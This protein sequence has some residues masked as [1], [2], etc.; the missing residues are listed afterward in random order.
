[1][2]DMGIHL[3]FYGAIWDGISVRVE[4]LTRG[5]D[6]T[7]PWKEKWGRYEMASVLDAVMEGVKHIQEHYASII[8]QKICR[9]YPFLSSY[10]NDVEQK[11]V[12]F[13]YNEQLQ[14]DTLLFSATTDSDESIVVKFTT[15][16]SVDAHQHMAH[17]DMAPKIRQS[18]AIS[19]DWLAIVMDLSDYTSLYDLSPQLSELQWVKVQSR[20][21][22]IVQE[23]H[24]GCF[25]HGDIRDTNL[26]VDSTSLADDVVRIHLVDFDWAVMT[27][28]SKVALG[29][30]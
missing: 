26:L 24:R 8:E 28:N 18:I 13:I 23:L 2:I 7:T 19:A 30:W 3:N 6:L 21:R 15:Q 12:G 29:A 1:M 10:R 14:E 4:P 27:P 9:N 25:V 22:D 17:L 16:Y 11:D 20:V 5:L